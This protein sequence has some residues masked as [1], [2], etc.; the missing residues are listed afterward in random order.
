MRKYLLAFTALLLISG[1]GK[2]EMKYWER[3]DLAEGLTRSHI[4]SVVCKGDDLLVG[5]YGKGALFS[6]DNGRTWRLFKTNDQ[7]ESAGL[8]WN[9]ITGGDW[10][11]DEIILAT[12]GNGLN[13]STDKGKTWKKLDYNFFG[14]EYLYA[15]NA[16]IEND[17]GYFATADGVIYFK[18][19]IDP[20]AEYKEQPYNTLDERQ[21][22]ASQYI[23]DMVVD[24]DNIYV[25]SLRG[26]SVSTDRGYSWRN[27]SPDG[28]FTNDGQSKCK[29][30]AVAVKNKTWYAGCDN[31]LFYSTDEGLNWVNIS[32]GLPSTYIHDILIDNDDNLWAAT[33]KGVAFTDNLGQSYKIYGKTSGFYGDNIN[34]LAQAGDGN[35]YAGT[36][37][38]LYRM[39]EKISA[40]N[41][42]PEAQAVFNK[43]EKPEHQWMLRPVPPE[44]NNMRDQT[45]LYG[46]KF[47]GSFRQHQ[48][49]EYNNPEGVKIRAV[50][51]GT[52][53]YTNKRIGHMVLRCNLRFE[54]YYVYAHYHHLHEI[55]RSVGRKVSRGDIIGAVGKKG[56]VTNEHLHFEVSFSEADDSNVPNKTVNCELWQKPLPGCGTIV[57]NVVDTAGNRVMGAKIYG[58]E[59]PAPTETPF[60]Y[61]ETYRDSVNSSPIYE[62]NFVIGDVPTGDYLLW[63]EENG[64]K[65]AVKAR[66]GESKVTRVKIVVGK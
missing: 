12:A 14:A 59:K 53:V 33:Y 31:G 61:A 60:S 8:S 38:G 48:G 62:E 2:K 49:C 34:C 4:M 21:G 35:I 54:D 16:V 43:L 57:G 44:D 24:K 36:N 20:D 1:C 27:F 47:D 17:T 13:I 9:Y 11:A 18:G 66:V 23:Y 7:D 15:V 51:S 64:Q 28:L 29:V 65:Y 46:S 25:G 52:I 55:Y 19:D 10:K 26:F 40:M 5:T 45:Y 58:V 22:L 41:F 39:K 32:R 50:A 6:E 30:R 37:Y 63:V 3:V 42:Y 56:N